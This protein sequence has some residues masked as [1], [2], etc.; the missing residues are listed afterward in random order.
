M[1]GIKLLARSCLSICML[2]HF[3]VV[4]CIAQ[5]KEAKEIDITLS[6]YKPPVVQGQLNEIRA[7]GKS[8]VQAVEI[9]PS[10]GIS[11]L[12]IKEGT[13]DPSYGRERNMGSD[14]KVWII[15]LSVNKTAQPGERSMVLVTSQGRSEPEV[16]IVATHVPKISNFKVLSAQQSDSRIEIALSVDDKVKDFVEGSSISCQLYC[17][18]SFLG[19]ST[20]FTKNVPLKDGVLQLPLSQSGSYSRGICDVVVS[21]SDKNH[22]ESNRLITKVEFK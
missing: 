1:N 7:V 21:V 15:I 2:S 6:S 17:G 20:F 4:T 12:E 11:S 5:S 18:N 3:T 16:I 14:V 22:Y 10:E 19:I 9:T 8:K 13:P